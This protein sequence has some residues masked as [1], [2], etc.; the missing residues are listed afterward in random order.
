MNKLLKI[1][2]IFLF[3]LASVIIIYNK[4]NILENEILSI[5]DSLSMGKTPFNSYDKSYN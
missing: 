2:V 3:A 5:G 1:F 4:F